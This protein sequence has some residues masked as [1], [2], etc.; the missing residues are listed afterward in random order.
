MEHPLKTEVLIIRGGA[1]GTDLA[2]DLALREIHC[3]LVERYEWT[4]FRCA[5]GERAK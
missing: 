3:I 1:T 2:Q 4:N 5:D